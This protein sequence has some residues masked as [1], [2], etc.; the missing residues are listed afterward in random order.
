[1][2]EL[3]LGINSFK[4]VERH[5]VVGSVYLLLYGSLKCLVFVDEFREK[6]YLLGVLLVR[7][8][9]PSLINGNVLAYIFKCFRVSYW[10][11]VRRYL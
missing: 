4:C 10:S 3:Y 2:L 7:L 11:I 6:L 9:Q 8:L 1:M 5:R